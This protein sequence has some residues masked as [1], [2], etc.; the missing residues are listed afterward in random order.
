[1]VEKVRRIGCEWYRTDPALGLV[2]AEAIKPIGVTSPRWA[3]KKRTPLDAYDYEASNP[4]NKPA[5]RA[6]MF[7]DPEESQNTQ[8]DAPLGTAPRAKMFF[9]PEEEKARQARKRDLDTHRGWVLQRAKQT[10]A[11]LADLLKSGPLPAKK[12]L[13]LAKLA[14][15]PERSLRR[16]KRRLGVVS[17][18]QGGLNG[19]QGAVWFWRLAADG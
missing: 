9:D 10:R 15:V 5:P 4:F 8:H 16:A 18:K 1:M 6:R 19:R 11:W 13:Y 12:V 3:W 7:F 17:V 2:T 14:G